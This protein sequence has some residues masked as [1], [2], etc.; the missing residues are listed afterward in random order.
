[1]PCII[2]QTISDKTE[3]PGSALSAE[4]DFY[5]KDSVSKCHP[6]VK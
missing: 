1:M 6:G 2:Q 4:K 3:T 5:F